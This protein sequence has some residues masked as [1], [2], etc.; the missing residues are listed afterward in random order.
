[1]PKTRA[2]FAAAAL[3]LAAAPGAASAAVDLSGYY[4]PVFHEDQ[5]ERIPGPDVGDFAGLPISDAAR[6]RGQAWN[7]SVITL[8]ER[9]C[10]PHAAPYAI[11]G[12]G[13]LHLVEVRDPATQAVVK[14]DMTIVAYTNHRDIW[15]DGRDHPPD[16]VLHSWQGVSTARW[17]GDALEVR[18]THIKQGYVR[19]NG[20]PFSDRAT[21]TER[22]MLHG[23]ILHHVMMLQD[24]VYLTEPLV[25]TT[26]YRRMPV[27]Q[28]NAYPCRPAVEIPRARGV[29]PHNPLGDEGSNLE[30]AR[31]YGLPLEAVKG[32]AATALPEFMDRFAP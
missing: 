3:V 16:W 15:M 8:P 32:G 26:L 17:D 5:P 27:P 19:R 9:Q 12:V 2:L 23:D 22:F 1:M 11:R 10:L 24:P 25:K 13:N 6:V 31:R 14:Y 4:A 18:T 7:A 20:L 30:Y 29:V 21:L 28:M